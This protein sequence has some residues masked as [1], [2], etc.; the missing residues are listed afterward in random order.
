MILN[1]H[2]TICG[3]YRAS[4]GFLS[5]VHALPCFGACRVF[6][7]LGSLWG[8]YC[9][10]EKRTPPWRLAS[11]LRPK[12]DKLVRPSGFRPLGFRV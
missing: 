12:S 8:P 7:N 9:M 2:P 4:G 10:T 6:R 1:M 3:V 5:L 11:E